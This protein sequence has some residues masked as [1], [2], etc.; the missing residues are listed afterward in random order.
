LLRPAGAV[1]HHAAGRRRV[2]AH[3]ATECDHALAPALIVPLAHLAGVEHRHAHR[4]RLLRVAVQLEG[5]GRA[6]DVA[7]RR[8]LGEAGRALAVEADA[9]LALDAGQA[10]GAV[11]QR[12]GVAHPRDTVAAVAGLALAGVQALLT[13][14]QRQRAAD[15]GDAGAGRALEAIR[16]RLAV[17]PLRNAVVLAATE[18][19]VA[20]AGA[21]AGVVAGAGDEGGV[22]VAA[23]AL[24]VQGGRAQIARL[25]RGGAAVGRRIAVAA[26]ALRV[27]AVDAALVQPA[28]RGAGQDAGLGDRRQAEQ[29][30]L[31][32][33]VL[34]ARQPL[35]ARAVAA[36]EHA[37]QAGLGVA[38]EIDRAGGAA[39]A[40]R[41][42]GV[43][44]RIAGQPGVAAEQQAVGRRRRVV[45]ICVGAHL[46]RLARL[47]AGAVELRAVEIL[48][49]LAVGEAVVAELAGRDAGALDAERRGGAAGQPLRALERE[50]D[51]G[52]APALR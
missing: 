12:Q 33:L 6:G 23:V 36:A 24:L 40:R 2:I 29:A 32:V 49:A 18:G 20:H 21:G 34:G 1:A 46:T 22:A 16:A 7:A 39:L 41:H 25:G 5:A 28:R 9:G 42:A 17:R 13:V 45:R 48:A 11:G 35:A 3:G 31:A 52:A 47:L 44:H 51:A 43:G 30:L 50:A 27:L 14:G 19:R 15:A 4:R 38:V 37:D 26:R 10:G 8:A